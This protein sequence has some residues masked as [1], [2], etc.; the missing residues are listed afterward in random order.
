MEIVAN[1]TTARLTTRSAE[2]DRRTTEATGASRSIVLDV[3]IRRQH[4]AHPQG[5]GE[6]QHQTRHHPTPST[7]RP[8]SNPAVTSD[9]RRDA[10]RR[11]FKL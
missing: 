1:L 6:G 7:H 3:T 5:Q 8:S 11:T 2:I 9:L 10:D 4:D